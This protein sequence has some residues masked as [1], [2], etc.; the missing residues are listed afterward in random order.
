[1]YTTTPTSSDRSAV[2]VPKALATNMSIVGPA[3]AAA[4]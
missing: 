3:P 2:V 1:L 4:P